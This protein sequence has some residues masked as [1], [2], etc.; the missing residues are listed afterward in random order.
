MAQFGTKPWRFV[1]GLNLK[2]L[3]SE[4]RFGGSSRDT[5]L[6]KEFRNKLHEPGNYDMYSEKY[7]RTP[8]LHR[9]W[10]GVLL[11]Y[12]L[13]I[14]RKGDVNKLILELELYLLKPMVCPCGLCDLANI[15]VS[16]NQGTSIGYVKHVIERLVELIAWDT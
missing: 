14:N 12:A 1:D 6:Y 3:S 5:E 8:G 4:R 15:M 7:W 2:V 13:I 11:A 9:G 16:F 10:A